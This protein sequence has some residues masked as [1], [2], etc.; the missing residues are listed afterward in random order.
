[1]QPQTISQNCAFC[2]ALK[3]PVSGDSTESLRVTYSLMCFIQRESAGVQV[4]TFH[5]FSACS[6]KKN[7]KPSPNQG[8]RK[9]VMA[10]PPNNGVKKRKSH[11]PLPASLVRAGLRVLL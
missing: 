5:Q 7:T 8:C 1:M 9:R 3:K 10:P 6:A 4:M 2:P 11:D